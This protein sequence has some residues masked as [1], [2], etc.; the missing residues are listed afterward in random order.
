MSEVSEQTVVLASSSASRQKLLE[1]AGVPHRV[2]PSK[3][4]EE[5]VKRSM[6]AV[7]KTS[8]ELAEALA[9]LKATTVS[10]KHPGRLVLGADQILDCDGK[11][12]DKPSD[13]ANAKE[14]LKAL[15]GKSHKLISYAVIVQD[16]V[17]VWSGVD[18]AT[19]TIRPNVSDQFIDNYIA[20]CGQDI[21]STTGVYKAESL[22]VQLFSKIEGNHY[23]I[24]GLPLLSLL[25]YLRE[26]G[27]LEK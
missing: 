4:D 23:A 12:F 20:R 25:D 24:L 10:R 3:V 16:S 15:R 22:G 7:G 18:T 8:L 19:V 21:L 6:R 14:Q 26:T 11:S 13:F 27:V 9:D 5:E 1:R 2:E 17:R